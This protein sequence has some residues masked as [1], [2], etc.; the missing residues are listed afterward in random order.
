ME[1][2]C[3]IIVS[4]D[5]SD[6]HTMASLLADSGL[7]VDTVNRKGLDGG[8]NLAIFVVVGASAVLRAALKVLEEKIKNHRSVE[9]TVDG[10]VLKGIS[11]QSVME[12]LKP[13]RPK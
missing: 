11:E 4:V 6:A 2:L 3:E 9:V 10:I 7:Q 1:D 13:S 12:L 5:A 8:G